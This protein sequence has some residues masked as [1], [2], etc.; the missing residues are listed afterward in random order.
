[1][2]TTRNQVIRYIQ[3]GFIKPD[4][5]E[6]ALVVSELRPSSNS[7][8]AF[9]DRVF[10]LLGGLSLAFA[11]MFFIAY[12]WNDI[13]RFAKFGLVQI[14]IVIAIGCYWKLGV[15]KLSAKVSLLVGSILIGVLLALYGQTYQT[16]ADPWQLFFSWA[17]L[18]LSWALL[19]RFSAIWL[20]WLLLVNLSL[21]LYH[22]TI[23]SALWFLF[24][25][26][27]GLLWLLFAFN[28]VALVVW[29]FSI[30]YCQWLSS[31]WAVRTLAT[32]SGTSITW[33]VMLAIFE[34]SS[35]S[36]ASILVWLAWMPL[37]YL[38]YRK[39]R[40]DLFMLAGMCLSGTLVVVSFL[41][42]A[43][44]DSF[45]AGG[46]LLIAIVLIGMGSGATIWLKRI[47]QEWQS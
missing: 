6:E 12:N 22:Q 37:F 13:G 39:L 23:R 27:T 41:A 35:S 44:I 16:G 46:F 25:A 18:I 30:R 11:L 14:A 42:H 19:G 2:S 15:D 28:I 9:I 5:V 4:N 31:R 26:E 43:I 29:E 45:E 32:A 17:L 8:H 38:A 40:P 47:H 36:F 21:V 3:Q 24:D 1:M 10:L 34:S 33:L 20:V 7:W